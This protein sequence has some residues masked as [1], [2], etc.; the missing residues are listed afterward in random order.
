MWIILA[1]VVVAVVY[2]ISIYNSLVKNRQ[3]VQE[4]WS[5]I[6]VQLKRRTD[7]IP[8][9][10]EAVKGYMSHER[11]TLQAVT[12]ARTNA[13]SAANASPEERAK[14]EGA[15]SGALGRLIAVAEAYPD[16]KASTNFLEFQQALQTIEDEIQ[17]SRR[18]Y[19]GAV[20]NLNTTV[21]S[22]PSNLIANNFK[23]EKAEYFELEN[24]ADRAVPTVKF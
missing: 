9:L 4:G 21:E 10:M 1:V 5:G 3:L 14:A 12:D 7:L 8:N 6:D 16:L 20:R 24:P 17:L 15:L 13:Q 22:F 19:N 18:Y 23:F 11:D 2:A